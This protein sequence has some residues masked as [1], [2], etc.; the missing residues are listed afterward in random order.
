MTKET[1]KRKKKWY[2]TNQKFGEHI[3][4]LTS[5]SSIDWL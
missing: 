5:E 1:E 4:K 2:L 3:L